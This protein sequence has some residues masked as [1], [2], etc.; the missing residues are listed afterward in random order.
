MSWHPL[1]DHSRPHELTPSGSVLIIKS[2]H[3]KFIK[4]ERPLYTATVAVAHDA[5]AVE[6]AQMVSLH[7]IIK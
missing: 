1:Q 5:Y 7:T 6:T 3:V 4:A 2:N